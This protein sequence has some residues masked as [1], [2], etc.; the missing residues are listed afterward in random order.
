MMTESIEFIIFFYICT[1]TLTTLPNCNSKSAN[2][3]SSIN[4]ST[5]YYISK[6]SIMN[7]TVIND[8]F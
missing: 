4:V 5:M 7:L 2:Q 6:I 8:G 3:E 1:V